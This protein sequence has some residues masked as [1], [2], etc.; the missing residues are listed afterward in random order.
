[1]AAPEI[2]QPQQDLGFGSV[3]GGANEKRLLN[4]DGT[5]NP[6]REGMSFLASL[7]AFHFFLS[8]SWKK[9]FATVVA[10]YLGT[11]VIFALAYMACGTDSIIGQEASN[12]G[13]V[14]DDE[15]RRAGVSHVEAPSTPQERAAPRQMAA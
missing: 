12:F 14:F 10:G 2:I 5:F 1:V 15:D 13:L 11:N 7:N 3:V 6:R 9:F 4:R 8:I